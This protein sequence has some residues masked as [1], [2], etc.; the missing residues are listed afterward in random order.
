LEKTDEN[1][2][3]EGVG[4]RPLEKVVGEDV[5]R[6]SWETSMTVNFSDMV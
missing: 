3:G 1:I 6:K 4:R 5:G 2:I